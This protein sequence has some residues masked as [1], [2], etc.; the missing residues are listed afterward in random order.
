M[1]K[2]KTAL[3]SNKL[4]ENRYLKIKYFYYILELNHDKK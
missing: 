4:K 2:Q 3:V 1:A